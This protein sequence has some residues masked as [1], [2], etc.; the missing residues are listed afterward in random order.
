MTFRT[1]AAWTLA[2]LVFAG[3]ATLNCGAYRYGVGD[4]AFYIP[5]ILRHLHPDFFPRDRQLIDDQDRLTVTNR[6]IAGVV[7]TTGI[8]IPSIFAVLYLASLGLAFAG[9]MLVAR[10][11]RLSAWSQAAFA[12]ALTL[13]HRIGMTAVNS[14]EGY[15]H[16]RMLAWGIG[17]VAVAAFLR[18]RHIVAVVLAAL[19]VLVHP[20]TGMWFG[21][22]LGAAIMISDRAARP[23]LLGAGAACAL[24]GAWALTAGPLA[25]QVVR[26]DPDWL[27]VL[28]GKGY[29]FPTTWPVSMWLVT[30]L[31]AIVVPLVF[32]LRRRLGVSTPQERGLVG[33]VLVL[34]LIFAVTLPLVHA[35]LAIA[36]QLQ[37]SRVFWMVDFMAILYAVWLA[38]DARSRAAMQARPAWSGRAAVAL[39]VVAAALGRGAYVTLVEHA[40]QAVVR[41]GPGTGEWEDAMG[42]IARTPPSTHVLVDPGHS[43]RY[44]TSA[45]VSGERD[46]FLEEVKDSAMAMYSR[47]VA[48]RVLERTRALGDFQ[49]LTPVHAR[50]VAA[51]YDVDYLVTE[52]ALDLPVAYRNARFW[53]YGLKGPSR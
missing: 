1:L 10:S 38:V 29:L 13:R 52:H 19:A 34:L 31:Y 2:A 21:I 20:T 47:R 35:R 45:R 8:S 15:A 53:I 9:S 28:S 43:Y 25:A 7:R 4:Q 23:W 5:G 22:W 48:A 18:G 3:V 6:A 27:Q 14:L 42:W 49:D 40:G 41:M 44:G 36:V 46:T 16:P 33:G 12:F 26:M 37:I 39:I 30:A 32:V 24:A 50:Q 11:L 17:I 51:R